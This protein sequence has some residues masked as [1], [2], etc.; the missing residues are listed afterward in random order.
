[1]KAATLALTLAFFGDVL[2]GQKAPLAAWPARHLDLLARF[3]PN[4][5]TL[6]ALQ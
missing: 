1:V 3:E 4:G 6:A 5:S 2:A